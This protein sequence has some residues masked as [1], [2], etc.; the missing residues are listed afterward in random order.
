MRYLTTLH[1]R[2]RAYL[3][4]SHIAHVIE[5][6]ETKER[7]RVEDEAKLDALVRQY[8]RTMGH[9]AQ[10]TDAATLINEIGRTER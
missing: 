7:E 4:R 2:I 10:R 9:I 8:R 1:L 3:Q 6:M 5:Q